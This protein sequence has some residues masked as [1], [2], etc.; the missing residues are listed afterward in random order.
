MS[1][2][3]EALKDQFKTC[4]NKTRKP[5]LQSTDLHFYAQ[6]VKRLKGSHRLDFLIFK[7]WTRLIQSNFEE[8]GLKKMGNWDESKTDY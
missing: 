1:G 4:K 5:R 8:L 7:S 3:K 2:R 6:Y